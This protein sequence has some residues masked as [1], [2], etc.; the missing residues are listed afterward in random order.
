MKT[1][2]L[3]LLALMLAP[4]PARAESSVFEGISQPVD[5]TVG[6]LYQ[7]CGTVTRDAQSSLDYGFCSG[8][9]AGIGRTMFLTGQIDS[10]GATRTQFI[11]ACSNVGVTTAALVQAF[12]NWAV[13]HPEHWGIQAESGVITALRETWPC[14][15]D[16]ITAD[17]FKDMAPPPTNKP[18]AKTVPG[19]NKDNRWPDQYR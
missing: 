19:W 12:K 2:T 14:G 6:T 5:F 17:Q 18:A 13:K 16:S 4:L 10:P 3:A 11:V 9:I 8:F 15:D 7:V 1:A